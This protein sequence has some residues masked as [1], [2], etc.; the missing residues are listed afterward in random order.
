M[1]V[2]GEELGR[3]ADVYVA[4]CFRLAVEC[5]SRTAHVWLRV[6]ARVTPLANQKRRNYLD[7]S[8]RFSRRIKA[9]D[10]PSDDTS[11]DKSR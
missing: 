10:W 2:K 4:S 6:A 7:A 8:G 3:V 11:S 5:L 9:A 1:R